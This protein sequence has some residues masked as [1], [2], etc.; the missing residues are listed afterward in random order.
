MRSVENVM[1]ELKQLRDQSSFNSIM[2][3]DDLVAKPSWIEE[4]IEQFGAVFGSAPFF[5]Q[6]HPRIIVERKE[7]IAGLAKIG[8]IWV[9]LGVESGSNRVLEFIKKETTKEITREA[10]AILRENKVKIFCNFILGLP[11]ETHAE[12][13]ETAQFI[14]EIKPERLS[15]SIYTLFPGSKL[16]DYCKENGLI[17]NEN[18]S[19]YSPCCQKIKNIDYEFLKKIQQRI[20]ANVN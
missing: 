8:L 3:H 17:L 9:S 6:I 5:M 14:E 15:P 4:F 20:A 12:A 11:T 18:W 16:Y 19:A 2:F 10:V 13:L 1:A 7:L